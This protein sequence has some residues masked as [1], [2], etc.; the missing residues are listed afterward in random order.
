MVHRNLNAFASA[1]ARLFVAFVVMGLATLS[2]TAISAQGNTDQ[3]LRTP[4]QFCADAVTAPSAEEAYVEYMRAETFYNLNGVA[5]E[6][7]VTT[8]YSNGVV[9][10]EAEFPGSSWRRDERAMFVPHKED[11]QVDGGTYT[12]ATV[13]NTGVC[14]V[15]AYVGYDSSVL[16]NLESEEDWEWK[17]TTLY[18]SNGTL[19]EVDQRWG[20]EIISATLT[21][22]DDAKIVLVGVPD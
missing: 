12:V 5:Y 8:D 9:V 14:Q 7:K 13:L 3:T 21:L 15:E 4:T 18:H 17:I 2:L 1:K 19:V 22:A 11:W 6:R 16:Y 20:G 10:I